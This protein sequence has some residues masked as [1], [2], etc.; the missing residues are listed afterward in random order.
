MR[1]YIDIIRLANF[2][3]FT[4]L[5]VGLSIAATLDLLTIVIIAKGVGVF[6]EIKAETYELHILNGVKFY[7]SEA[8]FISILVL[9][10]IISITFRIWVVT[11]QFQFIANTEANISTAL[12]QNLISKD[13]ADLF[14]YTKVEASKVILTE[15]QQV[16]GQGLMSIANILSS[17]LIILII[18]S[19]LILKEPVISLT[20]VLVSLLYYSSL[21]IVGKRKLVELGKIRSQ[22]NTNK[23]KIIS[24]TFDA[25]IEVKLQNLGTQILENFKSNAERHSKALASS[26]LIALLPRYFL[27]AIILI[28]SVLYLY[29]IYL[30]YVG[31]S[32][33]VES[34]IVI[35]FS[36][37]KI[38]PN[39]QSLYY[40]AT[41]L[42]Y[43]ER[44]IQN[45]KSLQKSSIEEEYPKRT[46]HA[47]RLSDAIY[48]DNVKYFYKNHANA[49]LEYNAIVPLGQSTLIK[50]ESGSGKSTFISL[51]LGLLT[52]TSGELRFDNAPAESFNFQSWRSSVGYVSQKSF[53]VEGCIYDNLLP[54]NQDK[55]EEL[56][57]RAVDVV[58]LVGLTE[59]LQLNA[60][61]VLSLDVGEYAYKLS[62]GQRQRLA[63][64]RSLMHDPEYLI[65]D[66]ATNALDSENELKLIKTIL[67]N[68]K[69]KT[70]ICISHRDDLN[71]YFDNIIKLEKT[72]GR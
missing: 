70:L 35:I 26:Q 56:R 41:Q 59:T 44:L 1:Q 63:L 2:R 7:I 64:A 48:F 66:E 65:L 5:L 21:L 14:D 4:L 50:G 20:M 17:F 45:I 39:A 27:E 31:S 28:G 12:M 67:R 42:K 16:V 22:T 58:K 32:F 55:K 3:K 68:Y 30:F 23:F 36:A 13:I 19:Y 37:L 47:F 10:I 62:G 40:N 69:N 51:L 52:P 25:I 53:F 54:F 71:A 29:V 18:S 61:E 6:S 11:R 43:L 57:P 60:D 72:Y 15:V 49:Q 33:N 9:A 8:V 24:E 46:Q 38:V 34:A